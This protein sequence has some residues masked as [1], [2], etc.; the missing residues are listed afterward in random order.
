MFRAALAGCTAIA[1]CAYADEPHLLPPGV[2]VPSPGE[3]SEPPANVPPSPAMREVLSLPPGHA[4][5]TSGRILHEACNRRAPLPLF[6]AL[7]AAGPD[8][9]DGEVN[10]VNGAGE[11]A[12]HACARTCPE[13]ISVLVA[14]GGQVDLGDQLGR[15]PLHAA[16]DVGR[17][18]AMEALLRAGANPNVENRDGNSPYMLVRYGVPRPE[19]AALMERYG[20]RLSLWQQARHWFR[21]LEP[22]NPVPVLR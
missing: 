8:S 13:C 7:I 5:D 9:E 2:Y 14:A 6:H 18:D 22:S 10:A 12:L 4:S 16:L 21:K 15:T 19:A 17:M 3:V 20:A 11:S 1:W